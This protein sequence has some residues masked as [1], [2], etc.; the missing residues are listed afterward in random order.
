[1]LTSEPSQPF[2]TQAVYCTSTHVLFCLVSH[3]IAIFY[4]HVKVLAYLPVS[5]LRSG[6]SL[7]VHM[8][9]CTHSPTAATQAT[10]NLPRYP[11]GVRNLPKPL[12]TLLPKAETNGW[13]RRENNPA[14][15]CQCCSP[16]SLPPPSRAAGG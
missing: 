15:Q 3:C 5:S 9:A 2:G 14:L 16:P 4:L 8:H 11:E 10:L 12:S 1:M 6:A 13:E 7:C